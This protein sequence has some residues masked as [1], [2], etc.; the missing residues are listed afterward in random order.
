MSYHCLPGPDVIKYSMFVLNIQGKTNLMTV[1][2]IPETIKVSND[3]KEFI[4]K[5]TNIFKY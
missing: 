1:S 5:F 4:K 3:N 2:F